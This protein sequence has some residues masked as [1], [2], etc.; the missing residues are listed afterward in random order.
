[1]LRSRKLRVRSVR[2]MNKSLRRFFRSEISK[3]ERY[4]SE[5][6]RNMLSHR[7]ITYT[8]LLRKSHVVKL[9]VKELARINDT[10]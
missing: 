1:M 7:N 9:L 8:L 5:Y 2:L 4:V 6:E 10:R 3:M